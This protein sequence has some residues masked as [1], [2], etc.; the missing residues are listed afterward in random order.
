MLKVKNVKV[1]INTKVKVKMVICK[2]RTQKVIT[3][4]DDML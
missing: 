1:E 4:E 2:M 3:Q